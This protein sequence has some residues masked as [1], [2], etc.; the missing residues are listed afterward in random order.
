MSPAE[1]LAFSPASMPPLSRVVLRAAVLVQAWE[2]RLRT[3]KHLRNL[4]RHLLRDIGLDPMA[5]D[6]E[7]MRPFWRP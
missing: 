4:D 1:T 2:I 6:A 7:A 3:R 5:A